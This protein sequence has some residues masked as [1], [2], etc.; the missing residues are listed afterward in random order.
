MTGIEI[1]GAR[2]LFEIP[3]LG[4]IKISETV[5]GSFIVVLIILIICLIFSRKLSKIPTTKTQILAEKFVVM[6]D[7]LVESTMGSGKVRYTPYIITIMLSSI[8]GSLIGLVGMRPVTADINT[9]L[10]W[11]LITFFVIQ[12]SGI[13]AKGVKKHY[14]GLLEPMPF[15]LPLNLVGELSTPVS[16]SFRHFGNI[17]SGMVINTL[18][19]A[20]LA[21][22]TTVIFGTAIPF[23][24]VGIPAFLSLYF[25]LFSGFMQAFIFCMLTMVF[26]ANASE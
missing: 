16:M 12:Y 8:F 26:V 6:M 20:G 19:Y 18:V 11:S 4:G 14:K 17:M 21:S 15:M 23:L 5:L 3:I 1:N 9:T 25:D 2:I 24:Q 7:N 13:K 22:L 10:T